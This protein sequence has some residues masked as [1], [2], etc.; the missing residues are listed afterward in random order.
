MSGSTRR[1]VF[2]DRDGVLNRAEVR[3]GRPHPPD[4]PGDVE[5]LPGVEKACGDLAEAGWTL[6]VVT[7]Q[8]DVARGTASLADVTAINE[9]VVAGLPITD[10]LMCTHDDSDGCRCRKPLPGL[11]VEAAER[12]NIDLGQSVMVGDRWRDVDAGSGAG[13][14]TIFIDRGYSEKQPEAPDHVVADLPAAAEIILARESTDSFA[15]PVS[16]SDDPVSMS[17]DWEGHWANYADAVSDNPA[18]EY[19]RQLIIGAIDRAGAPKRLLDIGSGQGDLLA[20]LTRRWPSAELAGLELSEEGIRIAASKV[21]AARFSALD[22]MAAT[23]VPHELQGWAD[24]AV[25]S[26]VLE[27]VDDPV[28]FLRAAISGLAPGGL[29]VVTV[30]GG[31]RS[32]FDR[33]I[34]HRRHFTPADLRAVL[35]D[36]GLHVERVSGTGFPFFNLYKLIVLLRG[37]ALVRDI[38]VETPPSRLANVVMRAFGVVLTTRWNSARFGWQVT[39]T[40]RRLSSP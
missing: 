27:H 10:V 37:R 12:W 39:A 38:S 36:A 21:P 9:V 31:P 32:Q 28:R 13:T 18:Q 22:L 34:G 25:C 8:P 40:A 29:L 11:L 33:F 30:P 1:A 19:R 6:I 15:D 17:D 3:H 4:R 35:L 14:R 26:E 23:A 5:R 24:V 2:L 16:M 20:D 7:N